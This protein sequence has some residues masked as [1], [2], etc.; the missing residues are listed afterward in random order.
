MGSWAFVSLLRSSL[1]RLKDGTDFFFGHCWL[2]C[3]DCDAPTSLVNLTFD[4]LEKEWADKVDFVICESLPLFV[5]LGSRDDTL[6]SPLY[7]NSC[8]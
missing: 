8:R 5:F 7:D 4:W 2:F 3:R 1:L 6:P